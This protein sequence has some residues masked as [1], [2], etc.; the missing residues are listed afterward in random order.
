MG[1]K[2]G[3]DGENVSEGQ[4]CSWSGGNQLFPVAAVLG[5]RGQDTVPDHE[6]LC[7][8]TR[9]WTD[10]CLQRPAAESVQ[11]GS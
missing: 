10:F 9:N 3:P 5:L 7:L 6:C 1:G 8:L 11:T 4:R 2:K